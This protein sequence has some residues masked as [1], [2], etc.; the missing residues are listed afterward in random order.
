LG[1]SSVVVVVR[2]LVV[3]VSLG[4]SSV[5]VVCLLVVVVSLGHSSVVVVVLWSSGRMQRS[6]HLRSHEHDSP[7][8]R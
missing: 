1:Q 6:W 5:V 7:A 3:V 2:F 8:F 4:H